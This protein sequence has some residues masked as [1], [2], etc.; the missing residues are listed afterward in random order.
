MSA[1]LTERQLSMVSING[2]Y[3]C[4]KDHSFYVCLHIDTV[5]AQYQLALTSLLSLL[6]NMMLLSCSL[7]LWFQTHITTILHVHEVH[8]QMEGVKMVDPNSR[9]NRN[10]LLPVACWQTVVCMHV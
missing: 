1:Q 2:A 6:S 7:Q 4:L 9:K 8:F 3:N 5:T 10:Q